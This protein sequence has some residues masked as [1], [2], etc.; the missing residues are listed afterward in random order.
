MAET[1]NPFRIGDL[2]DDRHRYILGGGYDV[3]FSKVNVASTPSVAEQCR[4][5]NG[6]YSLATIKRCDGHDPWAALRDFLRTMEIGWEVGRKDMQRDLR[7]L[8]GLAK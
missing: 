5:G 8:L 1:N 3:T 7:D 6:M 2:L 4:V